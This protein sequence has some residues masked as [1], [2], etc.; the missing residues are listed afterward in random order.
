MPLPE[1]V[2]AAAARTPI[3]KF[4]GAL[5]AMSAPQLGAAAIRGALAK[6][7]LPASAVQQCWM[8]NVVSA[9]VGQAPARQA[10]LGA[11]LDESTCCTT[12]NK[13]CSSGIKAIVLG[14]QQIQLEEANV[15][16]AGGME[17]MS[18]APYYLPK[19]RWG[20]RMGHAQALDSLIKDGLW[21][22]YGNCHMGSYAELCAETYDIS[23]EDQDVHAEASYDRSIAAILAE[24]FADEIVPVEV[25]QGRKGTVEVTKDEEPHQRKGA[26]GSYH[27][28]V[29]PH[30]SI[31][32]APL[33]HSLFLSA[34]PSPQSLLTTRRS[35]LIAHRS[36]LTTH[37]SPLTAHRSPPAGER[38]Q[39]R[40]ARRGQR[41]RGRAAQ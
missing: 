20:S 8:G 12:V 3:G 1:V 37:R 28:W 39:V 16:V 24:A 6:A 25:P 18:N 14:A 33:R 4:N 2:I 15:V 5:A 22:P 11:G 23:R 29:A 21:D 9:D 27:I 40:Q 7:K 13:V 31:S 41:S 26:A 10:A 35:P 38:R 19:A 36:P 34:H 32:L 30:S 17:S